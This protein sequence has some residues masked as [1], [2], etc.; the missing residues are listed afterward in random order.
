MARPADGLLGTKLGMTQVFGEGGVTIPVTVIQAGPCYVTQ[1]KTAERDG[2]NAIQLAYGE[3]RKLTRPERGHLRKAGV[4]PMRYLREFRVTNPTDYRLG[5]Q[6]T[7]SIFRPGEKVDVIG[8]SKGRGFAGVVKRH[9]F[10]G[11]PRTH[12]QSDRLRAPGS[13]GSGTTPGRVL[14]GLRMA[15]HMGNERVTIKNLEIVRV[16]PERN[17]LLVKGSVP[18]HIKG[19]VMVRRVVSEEQA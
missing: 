10:A 18:G 7:V 4:P 17:L 15:G 16:D 13:I 11:G 14:K 3:T 12:G 1:I 6:L 19:L 5:Q 9:G 2:Y 8:T